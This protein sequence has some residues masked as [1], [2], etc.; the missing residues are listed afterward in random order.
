MVAESYWRRFTDSRLS[1][2]R[3]LFAAA[4][5]TGGAVALSLVG[6]GDDGEPESPATGPGASNTGQSTG[7]TSA[8]Y[9]PVDTSNSAQTGGVLLDYITGD[10]EHFDPGISDRAEVI[11]PTSVYVYPRLM[12]FVMAKFPEIADGS[13]E[14]EVA[15]SYEVSG[16]RLQITFK[17]RQGMAWDARSP[18]NGRPIDAE[19]VIASWN[20]YAE[21]HP[22]A[23]VLV[24]SEENSAA[25]IDSLTR[26]DANTVVMKLLSPDHTVLPAL[27][28]FATFYVMPREVDGGFDPQRD[29]RGHGPWILDKYEPSVGFSFRRNPDYFRTNFIE[30]LER[31]ILPEYATR[32]AQFRAGN[33]YTSVY[34][35]ADV[36]TGMSDVPDTV[37][38]QAPALER[39]GWEL[40]YGYEGDSPFKDQRVR[41]AVSMAIDRD[42]YGEV[43]ENV[44]TFAAAG[45][46]VGM[47]HTAVIFPGWDHVRLDPDNEQEFGP[48][49]QY[50]KYNPDESHKLLAA[51]GYEDG[52]HTR[53]SNE[54][55]RSG[56]AFERSAE[57]LVALLNQEGLALEHTPITYEEFSDKWS[58][59]YVFS[60]YERTKQGYEGI[61]HRTGRGRSSLGALLM[62]L[63]HKNGRHGIW[64]PVAQTPHMGDPELNPI[65]ESYVQS[66]DRDEQIG[67]AHEFIRNFAGKMHTIIKPTSSRQ[68]TLWWPAIGNI[69]VHNT[70]AAGSEGFERRRHW[71]IDSSKAP[72]A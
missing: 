36:I 58:R 14:G 8:A 17:I 26:V 71:W 18:T 56:A 43:V 51:A 20:R 13:V 60:N 11:G 47:E 10:A 61:L 27:A 38:L 49:H 24:H 15:E 33:I 66:F 31:P 28:D 67:L 35:A 63:Y 55:G 1:R 54:T 16:D 2:R 53:F 41:Q 12:S 39:N 34:T 37:A 42:A 9:Q 62:E 69:G 70:L 3:A 46:D 6:C 48:N 64:D 45:L 7:A 22:T 30:R 32:Q 21:L 44:S 59:A 50:L 25:P 65:L 23:G 4:S 5:L 52:L 29:I 40:V 72:L 68:F 57:L 19:D